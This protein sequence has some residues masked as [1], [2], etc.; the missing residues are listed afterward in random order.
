MQD[1][2]RKGVV[3]LPREWEMVYVS[4]DNVRVRQRTCSSE[5]C[6]NR[7]AEIDTNHVSCS[8]ACGEL[9]V[10]TLAT[11]SFEHDFVAKKLRRHG[12]DPREKLFR[13]SLILLGEVLPLPAKPR[14]GGALIALHLIEICKTRNA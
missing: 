9:R 2:N 13:V 10:A 4:L 3:K 6:F 14:G 11:A 8:P 1:A 5:G 12:R 7:G